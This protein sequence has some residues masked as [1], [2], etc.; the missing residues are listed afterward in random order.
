MVAD[1]VASR[2]AWHG[3][4]CLVP[5]LAVVRA[6]WDARVDEEEGRLRVGFFETQGTRRTY[7][8]PIREEF[9]GWDQADREDLTPM[10]VGK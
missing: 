1:A 9:V 7:Y 8:D 4:G 2:L 5:A 3:V 10:R 6:E